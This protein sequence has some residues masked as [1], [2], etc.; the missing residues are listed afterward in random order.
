MSK[1]VSIPVNEN[2]SLQEVLTKSKQ[3]LV[4]QG[5]EVVGSISSPTSATMTVEKNN[6]GLKKIIGA[7]AK[8][9]ISFM[10]ATENTVM[11]NIED[12]WSS[13]IIAFVVFFCWVGA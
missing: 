8:S 7:G 13:K 5:Y 12:S 9:E 6:S 1:S 11:A 10:N 4:A 3:I 2:F